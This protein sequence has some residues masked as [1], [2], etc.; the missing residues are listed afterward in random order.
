MTW[1]NWGIH[2]WIYDDFG[3]ETRTCKT[4]GIREKKWYAYNSYDG[5]IAGWDTVYIP[6]KESNLPH[7]WEMIDTPSPTAATSN[8]SMFRKCKVCKI[9]QGKS[10]EKN[11]DWVTIFIPKSALTSN[12]VRPHLDEWLVDCAVRDNP[13]LHG[14]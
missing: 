12:R 4:C 3:R 11:T 10:L 8:C 2:R 6:P 5:N 7:Q 9:E 14:Y 13:N 1:C